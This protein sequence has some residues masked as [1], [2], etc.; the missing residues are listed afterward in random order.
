MED[1]AAREE[2]KKVRVAQAEQDL[3]EANARVVELEKRLLAVKNPFLPRPVL[4]PEEAK[5]WEGLG[6]A[7]RAARVEKQLAEA[8]DAAAAAERALAEA[9]AQ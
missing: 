8:R 6:G 7:E 1:R 4:P 9:K 5:A 3:A 2:A